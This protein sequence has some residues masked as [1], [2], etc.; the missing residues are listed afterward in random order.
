M[1]GG[2]QQEGALQQP[3]PP[4]R[5]PLLDELYPYTIVAKVP[6]TRFVSIHS[7]DPPTLAADGLSNLAMPAPH[8]ARS[9]ADKRRSAPSS[10]A[11]GGAAPLFRRGSLISSAT[12]PK[13]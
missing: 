11:A 2:G 13:V 8:M 1:V 9:N 5:F 10:S 4:R 3:L 7:I 6:V 12:T